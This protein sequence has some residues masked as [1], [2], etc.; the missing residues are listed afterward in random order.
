MRQS[1]NCQVGAH[2]PR[3]VTTAIDEFEPEF[4]AHTN[5]RCP[6]GTCTEKL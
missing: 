2:A 6:A 4:R 1:S 5:G 3:P